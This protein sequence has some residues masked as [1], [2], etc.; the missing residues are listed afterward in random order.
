ML[1]DVHGPREDQLPGAARLEVKETAVLWKRSG[2][3]NFEASCGIHQSQLSLGGHSL[4][5]AQ[6]AWLC[7]KH[8]S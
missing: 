2:G 4:R 5:G 3:G 8:E 1:L 7:R 6:E